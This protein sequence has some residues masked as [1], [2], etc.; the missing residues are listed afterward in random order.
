MRRPCAASVAVFAA[1]REPPSPQL[2]EYFWRPEPAP[3]YQQTY[4]PPPSEQRSTER[5][6]MYLDLPAADREDIRLQLQA[7]FES[8]LC[9]CGQA[10]IATWAFCIACSRRIDMAGLSWSENRVEVSAKRIV[11]WDFVEYDLLIDVLAA[12]RAGRW[13][14]KWK[15]KS[16]EAGDA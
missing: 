15:K 5:G 12:L 1:L 13:D 7:L 3:V 6:A 4:V 9:V 11:G 8:K 10:K 14:G 2:E 16:L